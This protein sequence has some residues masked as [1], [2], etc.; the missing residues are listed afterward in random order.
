MLKKSPLSLKKVTQFWNN[1]ILLIVGYINL[2]RVWE[3]NS[4]R[5][6]VW[7]DEAVDLYN[8]GE[9]ITYLDSDEYYSFSFRLVHQYSWDLRDMVHHILSPYPDNLHHTMLSS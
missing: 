6:N 7:F 4:I 3:L 9:M 1:H 8:N 5:F 2:R